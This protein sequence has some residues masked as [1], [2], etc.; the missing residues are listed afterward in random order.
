MNN[1]LCI[2]MS[3]SNTRGIDRS[4]AIQ[5]SLFIL[6]V[7]VGGTVVMVYPDPK[8]APPPPLP[9]NVISIVAIIRS[10]PMGGPAR[11]SPAPNIDIQFFAVGEEGQVP[12]VAAEARTNASGLAEV[13]LERGLYVARVGDWGVQNI[14]VTKNSTLTITRF[15]VDETPKSIKILALS[16][17]WYVGP[18][19]YVIVT[20][21]NRFT[22]PILL[23]DAFLGGKKMEAIKCKL[24]AANVDAGAYEE[25]A[26]VP[27]SCEVKTRLE[28]ATDWDNIFSIPAGVY[29]SWSNARDELGMALRISYTET[30]FKPNDGVAQQPPPVPAGQR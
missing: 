20:Y 19:D 14:I 3:S 22:K 25:Y 17:D 21:K 9:N 1:S 29:V 24:E 23:Q 18:S 10:Q 11:I 15:D 30:D 12:G 27:A 8:P 7:I 26:G 28:P 4:T 13:R 2:V 5:L 16:K 6:A